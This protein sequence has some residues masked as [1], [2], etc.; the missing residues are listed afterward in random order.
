MLSCT[1]HFT[2]QT[3]RIKQKPKKKSKRNEKDEKGEWKAKAYSQ[4]L[5]LTFD[6]AALLI[7]HDMNRMK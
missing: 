6:L 7:K 3:P 5:N 1:E 4:T 2:F